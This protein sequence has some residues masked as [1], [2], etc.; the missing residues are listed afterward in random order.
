MWNSI[1]W[2][3]AGQNLLSLWKLFFFGMF[4]SIDLLGPKEMI[5]S[6]AWKLSKNLVD[7]YKLFF[8]VC[9]TRFFQKKCAK[10]LFFTGK[11]AYISKS[12]VFNSLYSV[13][14][15]IFQLAQA[16][17][18]NRV[19]PNKQTNFFNG[20]LAVFVKSYVQQLVWSQRMDLITCIVVLKMHFGP[21]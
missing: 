19:E 15:K 21:L 12:C 11:V 4:V 5:I 18:E 6:F 8:D 2:G 16:L 14:E 3:K 13:T 20:K 1:I 9:Q 7:L 10:I 17:P